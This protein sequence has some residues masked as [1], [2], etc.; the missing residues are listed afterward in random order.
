MSTYSLLRMSTYIPSP[1][2]LSSLLCLPIVSY[3]YLVSY[4]YV[5]RLASMSTYRTRD[6]YGYGYG[7]VCIVTMSTNVYL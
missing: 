1:I 5:L 7:Y 6:A 2:C 4:T 3:A